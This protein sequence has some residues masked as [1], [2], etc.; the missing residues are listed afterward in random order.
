LQ[1]LRKSSSSISFVLRISLLTSLTA[2]S[3]DAML[4]ALPAI[5]EAFAVRDPNDLQLIITLLF[6]GMFVGELIFGPLSDSL[7][8][9]PA[10]G[11][12][13]AIFSVGTIMAM[14]APGLHLHLLG[15]IIQG[16]GVS[17]P[18]IISR[19]M[20]RDKFEGQE[21]ARVFSFIMTVFILVPMVAPI[22]GQT[23]LLLAGWR[24][25]FLLF[26]AIAGLSY[27]WI[28]LK[29]PET[30]PLSERRPIRIGDLLTTALRILKH[31]LVQCYAITAGLTFAILLL[32]L[33]TSQAM[34]AEIYDRADQFPWYMAFLAS[35]FGLATLLGGKLVLRLGMARLCVFANLGFTGIGVFL[36][37]GSGRNGHSFLAFMAAAYL[38]LFCIGFLF[39]NLSALAMQPLGRVAGLGASIISAIST[40][41]ALP[42]SIGVGQAFDNS[43]QPLA[44]AILFSGLVSLVLLYLASRCRLDRIVPVVSAVEGSHRREMEVLK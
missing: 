9:K 18:K 1:Q 30:L 17:G 11:L 43:L 38:I 26:L 15:R 6:A 2:L 31:P 10:L 21:M 42:L 16:I 8:R 13:I 37:T 7:G 39:P 44:L 32:F 27:L 5:G 4:P 24:A 19:A 3:I 36:L 41:I 33:S 25:I 22:L 34:F 14:T 35:G 23:I 12:G 40:T 29:Q 20:I 28:L